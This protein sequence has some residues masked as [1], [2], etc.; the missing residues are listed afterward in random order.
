MSITDNSINRI[1][2]KTAVEA[3]NDPTLQDAMA[4]IK[5][6]FLF[7][8]SQGRMGKTSVLVIL[9]M[10]LAKRGMTVG[11]LDVDFNHPDIHEIV[12]CDPGIFDHADKRI[13]PVSSAGNVKVASIKSVMTDRDE[14][15]TWGNPLK[16]SEI[17]GFISSV[18]WG[19][20]D[21]LFVDTPSGPSLRLLPLLQA[22]PDAQ[23]IIVTVPNKINIDHS[24]KMINFFH[25]LEI[26]IFGWIE[27]MEGFLCQNCDQHEALFNTGPPNRAIFLQELSFLGQIPI[28]P[29]LEKSDDTMELFLNKH[30]DSQVAEACN[31]IVEKI[32]KKQ[33]GDFVEDRSD[34]E[35]FIV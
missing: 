13:I 35:A 22:I 27:N 18:N 14:T 26:P 23:I 16:I 25:K 1:S 15:G 12:G 9:A 28:D 29:N 10:A 21:F 34:Y 5:H 33:S 17:Q 19:V 32:L 31:L 3:S 30:P 7:M 24:T 20:M 8:S 11:L 6:K 4:S 2:K